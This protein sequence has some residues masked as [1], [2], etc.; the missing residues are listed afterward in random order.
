MRATICHQLNNNKPGGKIFIMND[1]SDTG[2]CAFSI[3]KSLTLPYIS[4]LNE[5]FDL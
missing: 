2:F 1:K 4:S 3:L 5:I